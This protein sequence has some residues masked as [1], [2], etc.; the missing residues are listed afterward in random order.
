MTQKHL[1]GAA[2][3][4]ALLAACAPT[5]RSQ[6]TATPGALNA[7]ITL[8]QAGQARPL[9][10]TYD[11]ALT[12]ADSAG[13]RL[14]DGTCT[15]TSPLLSATMPASTT[16]RMPS[17]GPQTPPM[18]VTCT[19]GGRQKTRI[20][21]VVNLT[22]QRLQARAITQVAMR[23]YLGALVTAG[24]ADARDKTKDVWGHAP[25]RFDF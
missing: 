16:L 11:L 14:R 17:F 7:A 10:G 6:A 18:T 1:T 9:H 3:A 24:Q 23:G 15:L 22:A 8:T 20:V 4:L 25:V 13:T 12:L 19:Q 2:L 5:D 21:P